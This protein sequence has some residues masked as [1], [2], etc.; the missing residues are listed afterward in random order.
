M[1]T[2]LLIAA[3]VGCVPTIFYLLVIGFKK[4]QLKLRR[5]FPHEGI[6][7]VILVAIS[8]LCFSTCLFLVIWN[9]FTPIPYYHRERLIVIAILFLLMGIF[10]LQVLQFVR[11]QSSQQ[12]Q[13]IRFSSNLR[14]NNPKRVARDYAASNSKT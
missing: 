5:I 7:Q 1:E 10:C 6:T 14:R 13:G 2:K 9:F 11:L 12:R 4:I 3:L 8:L